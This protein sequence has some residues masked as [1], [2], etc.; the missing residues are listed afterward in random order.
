MALYHETRA[1][2]FSITSPS[3]MDR[4]ATTKLCGLEKGTAA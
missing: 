1:A 2:V 3:L 4:R